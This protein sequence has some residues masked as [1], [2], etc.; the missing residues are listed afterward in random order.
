[1]RKGYRVLLVCLVM[2]A[3]AAMGFAQGQSEEE[4]TSYRIGYI[5]SLLGHPVT[6]AWQTGIE[7][8]IAATGEDI[9]LQAY[10]AEGRADSQVT[11]MQELINQ[12][13]DAII[14]QPVD[15]AGLSAS[16]MAAEN[17]GI[18][19]ITLNTPVKVSH[20]AL[21]QMA[22]IEA[23]YM[24]GEELGKSIGGKGNVVIIQSPPGATLGVNREM[25]FRQAIEELYPEIAIVGAQNAEWKRDKAITVM[26]SFLQANDSISGVFAVNDTMAAGAV[27][28]AESAGRLE[29]IKIWGANG[30]GE[31]LTMI[32]QGRLA[33][34]AY[35]NCYDQGGR[36]MDIAWDVING[37]T[38]EYGDDT[39]I[40]KIDPFPAQESTIA[41]IT[42]E[43]RW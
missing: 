1:M 22:D 14:L 12:N 23:G 15:A 42:P 37:N 40:V 11:M 5:P 41:E 13:V 39:F 36:A 25:G 34:T 9:V 8:Y 43:N 32:E 16:V 20:T 2:L 19:V 3:V 27:I 10:D 35:N 17:A 21:V 28:A 24:V 4:Q 38:A 26:N 18:P 29:E 7:R 6:I 33:G 30:Q 31:A